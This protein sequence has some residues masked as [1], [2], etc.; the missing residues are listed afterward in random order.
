MA[1]AWVGDSVWVNRAHRRGGA[2]GHKP[3]CCGHSLTPGMPAPRHHPQPPGVRCWWTDP[4]H[5]GHHTLRD[6]EPETPTNPWIPANSSC[7]AQGCYL[8]P[9]VGP[10]VMQQSLGASARLGLGLLLGLRAWLP[11]VL[12]D[13][14]VTG[15]LLLLL[16][17]FF[18][19]GTD[20]LDRGAPLGPSSPSQPHPCSTQAQE[21]L[22]AADPA[23]SWPGLL[24]RGVF[25][26]GSAQHCVTRVSR[27]L[28]A[29]GV[30]SVG[31]P[32]RACLCPTATLGPSTS[33]LHLLSR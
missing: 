22:G 23:G 26:S 15:R 10:P 20:G 17:M 4:A 21:S 5:T 32:T 27:C 9:C 11:P 29:S 12:A 2:S 13:S 18:F 8:Q 33:F 24:D 28:A 7:E 30:Q 25:P 19:G 1:L 31:G 16:R 14:V 3:P 6:P